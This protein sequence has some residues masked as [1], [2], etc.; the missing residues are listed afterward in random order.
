MTQFDHDH[1][2]LLYVGR[3]GR[4]FGRLTLAF[5]FVSS[6]MSSDQNAPNVD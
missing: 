2:T 5:S 1:P 4:N 3:N 6:S